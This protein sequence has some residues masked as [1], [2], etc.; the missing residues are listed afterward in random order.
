[1]LADWSLRN[2][3]DVKDI[4]SLV[5]DVL[6]YLQGAID[7]TKEQAKRDLLM[8][9]VDAVREY[10][11]NVIKSGENSLILSD[12]NKNIDTLNLEESVGN[13][14]KEQLKTAFNSSFIPAYQAVKDLMD[15]VS[16]TGNNEEG[17]VKFKNGKEYYELLLQ[18]AVGSDKSV[19]EIKEL[20]EDSLDKHISKLQ[21]NVIKNASVREFLTS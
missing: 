10:C 9:D 14:Y 16:L 20:M 11:D 3:Q 2:E 8:I 21:E 6:P 19:M 1:M 13:A 5:N 15:E 17:L 18:N 4:I 7:Y 12:I